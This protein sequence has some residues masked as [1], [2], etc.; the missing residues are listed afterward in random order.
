MI[1]SRLANVSRRSSRFKAATS[2]PM[3]AALALAAIPHVV[4]A[5]VSVGCFLGNAVMKGTYVVSGKGT[6]VGVGPIVLA[7]EVV[8]NGD[9]TAVLASETQNVNGTIIRPSGVTGTY[10]V[11]HDCTGS[12]TFGSGAS[13]QHFDFVISPD[14]STITWVETDA[15]AV[16]SGKAVRVSND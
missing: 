5:D 6:V 1:F 7:G 4:R 9:G 11:N 10:T 3:L 8:Y 14:G 13:A 15:N 2:I 16:I 12:K